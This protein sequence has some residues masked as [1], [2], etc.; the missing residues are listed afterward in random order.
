MKPEALIEGIGSLLSS[1]S[2]RR[3]EPGTY[4]GQA[5]VSLLLRPSAKGVEFLAIKRAE[6]ERDPWSGHMALPGGRRDATDESLWMTA[7]R[8]TREEVHVDL[9]QVGQ[10]LGRLD[11]S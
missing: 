8:E 5:A 4:S 6:Q 3:A 9:Q 11:D 1:R 10:L 2:V 7:V